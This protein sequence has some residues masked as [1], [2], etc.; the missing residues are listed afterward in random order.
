MSKALHPKPMLYANYFALLHETAREMG[1]NL[2]I[3]GSMNR[4]MDLVAVAWIDDPKPELDLVKALHKILCGNYL[5]DL[6]DEEGLKRYFM[7]KDMPGGRRSYVINLN[8]GGYKKADSDEYEEDPQCYL[9]I[10]VVNGN[11][12]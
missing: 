5:E 11:K 7:Y 3:H 12:I 10:S 8:R 6:T 2:I 4:D 9:D 1:Y